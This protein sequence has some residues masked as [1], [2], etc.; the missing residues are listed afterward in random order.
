MSYLFA[1]YSIIWLVLFGYVFSLARRLHALR[2]E[3]D[4]MQRMLD[5]PNKG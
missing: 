1:A 4:Q 3:I 5:R 2:G